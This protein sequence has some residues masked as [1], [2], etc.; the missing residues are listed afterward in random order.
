MQYRKGFSTVEAL[1]I[2]LVVGVILA[3]GIIVFE[4]SR[5][6][7]NSPDVSTGPGALTSSQPPFNCGDGTVAQTDIDSFVKA[8]EKGQQGSLKILA[9]YGSN[10]MNFSATCH[11][12]T[13]SNKKIYNTEYSYADAE[14]PP[15]P[16]TK[17]TCSLTTNAPHPA[18]VN[19]GQD[20]VFPLQSQ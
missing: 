12:L 17:S 2:F 18:V 5:Q 3:V 14:P 20:D 6:A 4:R 10:A 8:Y 19:C 9:V 1:L 13:T 7:S 15:Y 16:I 11:S